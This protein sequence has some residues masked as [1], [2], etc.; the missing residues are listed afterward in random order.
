MAVYHVN[1]DRRLDGDS[2]ENAAFA[3]LLTLGAGLAT[4]IGA[5]M[6]FCVNT[7]DG[8]V[9]AICLSLAAGVMTYVSFVEILV[10]SQSSFA[11][12]GFSAADS[13]TLATTI[14]FSG[15]LVSILL[16][17]V[18][19]LVFHRMHTEDKAFEHGSAEVVMQ[20]HT[21]PD[22]LANAIT[23]EEA[24]R[25]PQ[26][27]SPD[28]VAVEAVEEGA[29]PVESPVNG[30]KP[31]SG[32]EKMDMLQMAAFSG[33]AIALHNFPEGLATFVAAYHDPSFGPTMAFAIAIHNIPE[34]LAVAAPI[35]KATGS[36]KKAFL[37][38]FLSGV[39]E[40]LGALLGWVVLR[41]LIGPITFA[42]LFGIIGGVMIHISFKKLIPTAMKYDP[43]NKYVSYSFFAGMA[44]M[45]LSLV[46]FAY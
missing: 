3:L 24:N 33:I 7:N 15:I 42:V 28:D 36:K 20:A 37:W 4:T 31:L 26:S 27:A 13:L 18:A 22:K 14:F 1:L 40:P 43:E 10:K 11:E 45:A 5:A 44:V 41:E 19:L 2:D 16:E 39:S 35:L 46:A 25:D 29:A 30:E 32:K 9:F 8:R 6:A 17:H 23:P 38:A 12:A 21:D 34:G